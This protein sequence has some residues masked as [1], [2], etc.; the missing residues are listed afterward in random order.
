MDT[1]S[2]TYDQQR[3]EVDHAVLATPSQS[4]AVTPSSDLS[5]S[6]TIVHDIMVERYLSHLFCKLAYRPTKSGSISCVKPCSWF[7]RIQACSTG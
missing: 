7:C 5:V 1:I 6:Q 2:V 3:K 4:A